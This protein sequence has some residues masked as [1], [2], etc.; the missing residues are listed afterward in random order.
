[1]YFWCI[2]DGGHLCPIYAL[3]GALD[4]GGLRR[5]HELDPCRRKGR[6]SV[7][8]AARGR[9]KQRLRKRSPT[10][11][12]PPTN[13]QYRA[14]QGGQVTL[15]LIGEYFRAGMTADICKTERKGPNR[16]PPP[17]PPPARAALQMERR[18]LPWKL[19]QKRLVT[20]RATR[21][22][23]YRIA[24]QRGHPA[25]A[26]WPENDLWNDHDLKARSLGSHSPSKETDAL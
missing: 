21:N 7:Q 23:D 2:P 26:L 13:F 22:S 3:V 10:P 17:P 12:A 18:R 16:P 25:E 11:R 9:S 8:S 1:M 4:V 5:R 20:C 14:P 15:L 19:S 24:G 6:R